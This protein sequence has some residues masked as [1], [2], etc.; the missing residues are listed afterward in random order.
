[1]SYK[2]SNPELK[3]VMADLKAESIYL[4]LPLFL[5]VGTKI[6]F[7][8]WQSIFLV[9]DWSL[10]S[11][12]IFGNMTYKISR[13]VARLDGRSN[14]HNYGFY[15]ARRFFMV[16][17]AMFFYFGMLVKPTMFLGVLQ[18]FLFIY[19]IVLHFVDGVAASKLENLVNREKSK[20]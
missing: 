17:L 3:K 13:S 19:A 2:S 4:I 11:C 8:S 14:H 1:M 15:T 18:V 6:Y 16:V 12:I 9:A 5:L 10:A 7:D 20:P